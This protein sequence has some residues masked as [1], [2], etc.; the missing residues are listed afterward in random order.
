MTNPAR[1]WRILLLD[2]DP[3]DPKWILASVAAPGDVRP[4]WPASTPPALAE[5]VSWIRDQ[6]GDPGATLTPMRHAAAW[7]IEED[8]QPRDS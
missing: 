5:A 1:P 8:G 7:R 3:A 6:T 2:P 4:A